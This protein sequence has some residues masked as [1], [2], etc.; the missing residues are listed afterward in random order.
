LAVGNCGCAAVL[1]GDGDALGF[2]AA[3]SLEVA[4]ADV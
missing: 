1:R 2:V 3:R 4:V